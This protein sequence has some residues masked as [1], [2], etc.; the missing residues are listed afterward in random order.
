MQ[1]KYMKHENRIVVFGKKNSLYTKMVIFYLIKL[2]INFDLIVDSD[3][4][5]KK[6]KIT[7]YFTKIKNLL[8]NGAFKS[9]S[10]F[11]WFTW[12]LLYEKLKNRNN[13]AVKEI[14]NKYKNIELKPDAIFSNINNDESI[15]YLKNKNYDYA[16]FSDVGIIKKEVINQ[17][18]I[19]CLNAHPAP[20]PECR[21]GGALECTLFKMLSPSVSVHIATEGIDE[22]DIFSVKTIKLYS[23]D[24]FVTIS[25]RLNEMCAIELTEVIN[26]IL[27]N[28]SINMIKNN[29]I[30][31]YWKDWCSAKQIKARQN[32][33][34]MLRDVKN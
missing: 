31:N 24:N 14:K 10:V 17:I 11:H 29:G 32:L 15:S 3:F 21:G 2:S 20:L 33:K 19:A 9:L 16:L 13:P 12:F 28:E 30:L 27:N 25:C 7:L 1:K 5:K 34:I 23:T 6:N 8:S 26:K 18:N 4:V 22:G